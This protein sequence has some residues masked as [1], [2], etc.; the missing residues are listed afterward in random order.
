MNVMGGAEAFAGSSCHALLVLTA[1]PCRGRLQ[2]SPVGNAPLSHV[3]RHVVYG[4]VDLHAQF[5]RAQDAVVI[6]SDGSARSAVC[7]VAQPRPVHLALAAQRLRAEAV[8]QVAALRAFEL[9]A[10]PRE[11][12]RQ[13]GHAVGAVGHAPHLLDAL[14]DRA[15]HAL[16][17]GAIGLPLAGHVALRRAGL[18]AV[19]AGVGLSALELPEAVFFVEGARGLGARLRRCPCRALVEPQPGGEVASIYGHMGGE[20]VS[21]VGF[22]VLV[23]QDDEAFVGAVPRLDVIAGVVHA[24]LGRHL[25]AVAATL[26]RVEVEGNVL[27]ICAACASLS[28]LVVM[29]LLSRGAHLLEPSVL[30][31]DVLGVVRQHLLSVPI[32]VGPYVPQM[33]LAADR[34]LLHGCH[35]SPFRVY[36][37]PHSSSSAASAFASGKLG[38]HVLAPIVLPAPRSSSFFW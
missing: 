17:L 13:L 20:S 23:V 4:V 34:H 33:T 36:S 12:A 15:P 18:S 10:V 30:V 21:A 11:A 28:G 29:E 22:A 31:D 3:P 6:E 26:I 19:H 14:G 37:A 35:L 8:L 2:A 25:A 5:Y 32:E 16:V 7:D 9:D 24:E 27:H 38:H 1:R